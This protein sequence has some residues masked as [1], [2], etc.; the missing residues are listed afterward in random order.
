ML[1]AKCKWHSKNP[2]LAGFIKHRI[3]LIPVEWLIARSVQFQL[4]NLQLDPQGWSL[5]L[6]ATIGGLEILLLAFYIPPSFQFAVLHEGVTFMAQHPKV[7]AIQMG[8][9]NMIINPSLDKIIPTISASN[10]PTLTRFGRFL[11]EFALV[12]TWRYKYP[13]SAAFSC[14]TPSHSAMSRIDLLLVSPALL[15][16]L[17]NAGFG[18]RVLSDHSPYWATLHL[19]ARSPLQSAYESC[20]LLALYLIGPGAHTEGIMGILFPH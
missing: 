6:H 20:S 9:F 1:Q 15:P 2:G 10:Q 4:H 3:P 19:P 13:T 12:D 18:V 8:D 17:L 16:N 5:F 11:S 7:P 14:F